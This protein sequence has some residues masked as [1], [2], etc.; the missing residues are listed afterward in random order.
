MRPIYRGTEMNELE[1][2]TLRAD[3]ETFEQAD[4]QHLSNAPGFADTVEAGMATRQR[5]LRRAPRS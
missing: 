3:G 5:T 1:F 4:P 2:S